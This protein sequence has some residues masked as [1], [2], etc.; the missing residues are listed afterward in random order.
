[1]GGFYRPRKLRNEYTSYGEQYS[2]LDIGAIVRYPNRDIL[3][4]RRLVMGDVEF[5]DAI[6]R[7]EVDDYWAK[8]RN[9]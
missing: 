1:M 4:M 2:T 7:G 9:L 6:G 3:G 5:D 8:L